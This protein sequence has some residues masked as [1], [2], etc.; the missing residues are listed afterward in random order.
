M[1]RI[2]IDVREKSLIAVY[3]YCLADILLPQLE[4]ALGINKL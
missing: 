3:R 2:G 4:D 1:T